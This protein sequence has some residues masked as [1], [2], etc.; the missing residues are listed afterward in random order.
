[1]KLRIQGNSLRLRLSLTDVAELV[2]TGQTSSTC[3]FMDHHLIYKIIHGTF[4]D[5]SAE[6]IHNIIT[7]SVPSNLVINWD[8]DDRTGFETTD[9]NGLYI[10]IEKDFQCLKP[11]IHEDESDL[12]PNPQ[13][14]ISS[15][16]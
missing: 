2:K 9:I 7:V 3:N 12:F 13:S 8:T 6:F 5:I 10:L 15:H 16:D 11:R 14:T 1:M 4:S